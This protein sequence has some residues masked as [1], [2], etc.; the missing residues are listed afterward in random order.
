MKHWIQFFKLGTTIQLIVTAFIHYCVFCCRWVFVGPSH[1]ILHALLAWLSVKLLSEE[2]VMTDTITSSAACFPAEAGAGAKISH[3]TIMKNVLFKYI[4]LE[5]QLLA[6]VSCTIGVASILVAS[7][8]TQC[9]TWRVISNPNASG[10]KWTKTFC[11]YS[12]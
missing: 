1:L 10:I 8:I 7:N 11:Q 12:V 9:G 3:L 4:L 2:Q 6:S 5:S